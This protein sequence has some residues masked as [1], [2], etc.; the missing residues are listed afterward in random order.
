VR[1]LVEA[2]ESAAQTLLGQAISHPWYFP[3]IAEFASVLERHGLEATYAALI[4]RPT[5]LEGEEGLR[6]WV[7][8]CGP[9]WLSRVPE[10]RHEEFF[11]LVEDH[12]RPMLYQDSRWHADYRRLRV[13]A[14]KT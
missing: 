12:A 6:N 14:Q 10:E 4:D 11:R 5:P 9:H 13:L 1:I 2:L 3:S 7:R 8:M